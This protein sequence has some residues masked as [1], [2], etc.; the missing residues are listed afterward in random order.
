MNPYPIPRIFLLTLAM[1]CLIPV[2]GY[3]ESAMSASD[4]DAAK[5]LV[6][7]FLKLD[8]DIGRLSSEDYKKHFDSMIVYKIDGK[9]VHEEPGWDMFTVIQSSKVTGCQSE[10]QGLQVQVAY[11]SLG[12]LGPGAGSNG[13][14]S[15][16]KANK[17]LK[18]EGTFEVLKIKQDL[19]IKNSPSPHVSVARSLELLEKE[20]Q[21]C[22]KEKVEAKRQIRQAAIIP[23]TSYAASQGSPQAP[24]QV[25][26]RDGSDNGYKFWKDTEGETA[27]FEY[28][29]IQPKE[30]STGM[31]SGGEPTKGVLKPEQVEELWQR[32][33]RLGA[34]LS[35]R[36][37]GRMKGT[38]VF[39]VKEPKAYLEF[40]IAR[41]PQLAAWDQFLSA[42]RRGTPGLVS[43]P[44]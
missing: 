44:K 10:G 23:V 35:L 29:P 28:S 32:A 26:Y 25:I 43:P 17:I 2:T 39:N 1:L 6:E 18:E 5:A 22:S 42:F 31:Y 19:K 12:D 41:G 9:I 24:W 8:A 4:C 27:R 14:C 36:A 30:S 16:F 40:T 37:E 13:E 38:G 33:R 3:G 7:K 34:D 15:S 20:G 11:E 21:A